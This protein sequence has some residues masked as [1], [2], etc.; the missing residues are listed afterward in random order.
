MSSQ[1]IA[2]IYGYR[3]QPIDVDRG[4]SIRRAESGSAL[5]YMYKSMPGM[6]LT[7]KGQFVSDETAKAAGFN[8]ALDRR[9]AEQTRRLDEAKQRLALEFAEREHAI[10]DALDPDDRAALPP[11]RD[12][13]PPPAPPEP[14]AFSG[15]VVTER[16]QDGAPRGTKDF[17]M[18]HVGGPQWNVVERDTTAIV[19]QKVK[20]GEAAEAMISAQRQKDEQSR[21]PG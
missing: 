14:P 18:V 8:V 2:E 16:S 3:P 17:Q 21:V 6:Y 13:A 12:L 1:D 4:V 7:P 19:V 11:I 15:D 20:I 10:R 9:K 5:V